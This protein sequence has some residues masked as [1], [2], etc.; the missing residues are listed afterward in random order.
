MTHIDNNGTLLSR[1][2]AQ[3]STLR[4]ID[5][6]GT[7]EGSKNTPVR[8]GEGPACHFFNRNFIGTS[9][10][11]KLSKPRFDFSEGLRF[12]ITKNRDD[13]ATRRSNGDG[14]VHIVAV[15][16]LEVRSKEGDIRYRKER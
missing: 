6:R 9:F 1:V 11:S 4:L 3:D 12:Y 14:N 8:D 2:H 13:E 5:D 16:D 15:H 10:R 7:H